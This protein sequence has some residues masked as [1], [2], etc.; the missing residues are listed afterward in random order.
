MAEDE[1][2]SPE[3]YY[4]LTQITALATDPDGDRVAFVASEQD[5]EE[6]RRRNSVFIVPTDGSQE[7]HRLTRA[8]DAG[9][10]TWSPDGSKLAILAAR[11]EDPALAVGRDEEEETDEEESSEEEDEESAGTGGEDDSPEQQVWVF[12]LER[13]GDAR[14]VTTR[15]HGVSE[16]DWGP[17]GERLVI[18]ARD[19]DE[20]EE[21][22]LDQVEDDGPIEI[23]RL[24]HKADGR[25]WL[26]TVATHL[27]IV[28]VDTRETTKLD[29]AY[30]A[31]EGSRFPQ[32]S[33]EWSPDGDRIAFV[34]QLDIDEPDDALVSDVFTITPDGDDLTKITDS[35]HSVGGPAWS[36]DGDRIAYTARHPRN[37]YRPSEVHVADRS[38]TESRSVSASLDRTLA[39]GG[40]PAWI[41]NDRLVTLI[42]DEGLT[43]PVV[44]QADRDDPERAVPA[45]GDHR[46]APLADYDGGTLALIFSDPTDGTDLFAVDVEDIHEAS[47]DVLTQLTTVN[48]SLTAEV[49]LPQIRR[50]TWANGDGDTVEGIVYFPPDFDPD[51]PEPHPTVTAIHGGPMSY[52]SPTFSFDHAFWTS[53]G[54]IVFRPNYRGST[55]YGREFSEALRGTRGDL[56]STDILTGIDAVIDA[57][58]ADPDRLFVTGFSYGGIT[59][60]NLVTRTDRFAAAAAEHGIY[61][62]RSTFGT[63]DNHIWH[64]DEFGLPWEEDETYRDISSITDVGEVETPT[65]L[66]AGERD[67]RCPPTQAEQFYV[68]LKKQGIDSKLVIYQG[69]NHNIGDPDRAI[70]RLETLRDW[71]ESHDPATK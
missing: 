63:D 12:D 28:D 50:M 44:L 61:D 3:D 62:F 23:E 26:D 11:E 69:E 10:P 46:T 24:Q 27:F 7:P 47:S 33:P 55:S 43:R 39:F 21:E 20:D 41:D 57:G 5:P 65:L 48:A 58:W 52:D 8:S 32:L 54:Y 64:E 70:H 6:D 56:E 59:T 16:V 1:G 40:N 15:E 2:L 60:A 22:Y 34:S 30:D 53:N 67:W 66:T 9:S 18:S 71:F 51:D 13:G 4:D 19:P 38:G 14:Q 37:W 45:Q 42:G 25:D 68:S 35:T 17:D 31:P 36:P 29:D 49:T